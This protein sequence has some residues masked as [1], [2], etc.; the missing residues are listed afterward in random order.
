MAAYY[1]VSGEW[2]VGAVSSKN[3]LF[4]KWYSAAFQEMT[5]FD[6]YLKNAFQKYVTVCP[7]KF[8]AFFFPSI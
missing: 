8:D 1:G 2:W 6:S 5:E 7:R 3:R 4:S